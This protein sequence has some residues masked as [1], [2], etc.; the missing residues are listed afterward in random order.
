[1]MKKKHYIMIAT[2]LLM[3]LLMGTVYSYSVFRVHIETLFNV[4]TLQSGLP[5]MTSLAFYALGVMVTG[6]FMKPSRLRGFVV[7]GTILIA[8]GWFISGIAP[9]LGVLVFSYGVLI[10]TGV[11]IVYGIPIYIAQKQFP[12][13]SGLITGIILLGFGMSPLI[14]A[15]LVKVLIDLLTIQPAFI[16]FGAIF[17]VIQLPIS[18][19]YDTSVDEEVTTTNVEIKH[20]GIKPFKSIYILFVMATTIG[21]MMIGLSYQIGVVYYEFNVLEV[22]AALSFFAIMNGIARP[23]F[24]RLMDKKGFVFSVRLSLVLIGVASII[25]ILN[26]GNLLILF[27]MSFSLFWFNL[28]AWL[29][30]VPAAIK[31][32]Y[33]MKQYSKVYGIMFTGYGI[34]AILGTV[35]SGMIMDLLKWTTNLYMLVLVL[36]GLSFVIVSLIHR[37]I[38]ISQLY[39]AKQTPDMVKEV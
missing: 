10:G 7:I 2:S 1:M 33:G 8:L 28:G 11:G 34:G 17:L 3:M 23:I 14:T 36:I 24:G 38:R 25:G 27:I 39:V 5:Y 20:Y 18:F 37:N 19:I 32:F 35:V 15:P 26:Q 4:G 30:I 21:L 16:V 22:T 29:A 12:E 9:S 13:K 31:S 6:R